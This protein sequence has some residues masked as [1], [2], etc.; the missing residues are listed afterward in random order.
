M[1]IMCTVLYVCVYF[2]KFIVGIV[3]GPIGRYIEVFRSS[4]SEVKPFKGGRPT[5]YSRP[6]GRGGGPGYQGYG[7]YGGEGGKYGSGYE[8]NYRGGRGMGVGRGGG[9]GYGGEGGIKLCIV[10]IST[11]YD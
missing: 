4:L 6:G 2:L 5:P 7:T 9:Y 11:V 10:I 8:R 1:G 3:N